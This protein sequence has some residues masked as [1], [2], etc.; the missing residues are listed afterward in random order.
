MAFI[1]FLN[2]PKITSAL[3]SRTRINEVS[4]LDKGGSANDVPVFDTNASEFSKIDPTIRILPEMGRRPMSYIQA[5]RGAPSTISSEH[6]LKSR[7]SL[8]P[9]YI[10]NE[11]ATRMARTSNLYAE[12]PRFRNEVDILA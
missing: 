3:T 6:F 5:P 8:S 4:G 9:T 2:E 12:A 11:T 7:A 1:P 10:H